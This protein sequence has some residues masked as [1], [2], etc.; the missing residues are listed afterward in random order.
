M[1]KRLDFL[2]FE[3]SLLIWNASNSWGTIIVWAPLLRKSGGIDGCVC[4][5][6]PSFLSTL[7]TVSFGLSSSRSRCQ[8][9]TQAGPRPASL[10][11]RV[12]KPFEARSTASNSLLSSSPARPETTSLS[13]FHVPLVLTP[14]SSVAPLPRINAKPNLFCPRIS[15]ASLTS[16][17]FSHPSSLGSSLLSL[18]HGS[19]VNQLSLLRPLL[20]RDTPDARIVRLFKVS[21]FL[22]F[23]SPF[24][25]HQLLSSFNS[26]ATMFY[27]V[28]GVPFPLRST[29]LAV[30]SSHFSLRS[31]F[32]SSPKCSFR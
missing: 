9:S 19:I 23:P 10:R 31:S 25:S 3:Q 11:A 12:S 16:L 15:S 21:L 1:N 2:L 7:L 6:R 5:G 20:Y 4:S 26:V 17:F 14:S 22:S 28:G 13:P 30:L 29:A 27:F 18:I 24:R 8:R 32:C